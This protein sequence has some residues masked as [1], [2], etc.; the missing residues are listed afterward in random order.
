M[1]TLIS[2]LL[3]FSLFSLTASSQSAKVLPLRAGDTLVT[4]SSK[5]TV[6]RDIPVTGGYSAAAIQVNLTE[7]SGTTAAKAYLYGSLDGVNWN[8]TD[9]S[10]AFTDQTTNVAWF[11]KT[12][13]PYTIQRVVVRSSNGNGAVSTFSGIVRIWYSFKN[14]LTQ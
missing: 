13:T 9:S 2:L 12:E 3:A 8:L 11:T 10:A 6:T 7:L 4:S 1:K 5:D 14:F